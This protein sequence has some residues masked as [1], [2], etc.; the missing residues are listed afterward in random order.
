VTEPDHDGRSA[1]QLAGDFLRAV[2][3]IVRSTARILGVETRDVSRRIGRRLGL[4]VAS[5]IVAAAGT[6]VLLGALAVAAERLVGVSR[7]VALG[8]V[9]A[10]A[11]A[12]GMAGVAVALRR[13]GSP[14]IAFPATVG[15]LEQDLVALERAGRTS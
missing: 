9:G 14:D 4:L 10:L 15:E 7:W 3:A 2:L 11:L 13:L 1:P 8:V 12:L 6:V 5:G